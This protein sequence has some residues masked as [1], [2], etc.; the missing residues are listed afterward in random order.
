V[1]N[2]LQLQPPV[3][4]NVISSFKL[5]YVQLRM[6]FEIVSWICRFYTQLQIINR[7]P[8]MSEF[9]MFTWEKSLVFAWV[10]CDATGIDNDVQ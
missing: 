5:F 9:G 1:V 2:Q 8:T 4:F 7:V 6:P 10:E 3:V